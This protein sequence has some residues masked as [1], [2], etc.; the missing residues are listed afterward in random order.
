MEANS[1]GPRVVLPAGLSKLVNNH[2]ARL[3]QPRDKAM[4][5]VSHRGFTADIEQ[6]EKGFGLH[7]HLGPNAVDEVRCDGMVSPPQCQHWF[8]SAVDHWIESGRLQAQEARH[9]ECISG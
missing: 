2:I 8:I 6:Q 3:G 7:F 9:L 1:R 4:S 5:Q